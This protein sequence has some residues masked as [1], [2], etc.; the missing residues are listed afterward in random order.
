MSH[1]LT[2]CYSYSYITCI[3][4]EDS[5]T[6]EP[7][8]METRAVPIQ[9]HLT[10]PEM[11]FSISGHAVTSEQNRYEVSCYSLDVEQQ[12]ID[13]SIDIDIIKAIIVSVRPSEPSYVMC[14]VQYF[15]KGV[16]VGR[17]NSVARYV[18]F[19]L[20]GHI[21]AN[22][23][24]STN[25]ITDLFLVD[26]I[27]EVTVGFNQVISNCYENLFELS[28]LTIAESRLVINTPFSSSCVLRVE[29]DISGYKSIKIN[30]NVIES[31]AGGTNE[32]DLVLNVIL[33]KSRPSLIL[34]DTTP[35]KDV[36]SNDRSVIAVFSRD[37][38]Y[39]QVGFHY[40]YD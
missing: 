22:Y 37:I 1:L 6:L 2:V 11:S 38:S 28:S 26:H 32:N 17:I 34:F 29:S 20:E 5:V 23:L 7:A 36:F 8:S 10:I 33:E 27:L 13:F 12:V 21:T 4:K 31:R 14:S 18:S 40:C 15:K 25:P 39:L 16:Y 30:R 35:F 19:A 24:P 3:D 9:F